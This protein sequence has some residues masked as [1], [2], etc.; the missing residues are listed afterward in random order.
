[1]E[2][3]RL[4]CSA[5]FRRLLQAR[6][7]GMHGWSRRRNEVK[8]LNRQTTPWL[9]VIL[10]AGAL[11]RIGYF[12]EHARQPDFLQPAV[13]A[14]YHDYWAFGLATGDWPERDGGKDLAMGTAPY[15]RPPGYPFFLAGVYRFTLCDMRAALAFQALLGLASCIVLF[16]LGRALFG[17]RAGLIAAALAAVYWLFI[18]YE[19]ELLEPVLLVLLLPAAALACLRCA[20]PGPR[21]GAAGLLAGALIG[22]A[23]LVKPNALALAPALA[24]WVFWAARRTR[25]VRHAA[26]AAAGLLAAAAMA[27]A[28]AAIRNARAGDGRVLISANGGINLFI[29]NHAQADGTYR[30]PPEIAPFDS[31]FDYPR[32]LRDL[33]V[34]LGRRVT[35]PEASSLFAARALD[36]M[37]E[38]P[39]RAMRL[40]GRKALL[41]WGPEEVPHNKVEALDRRGSLSLRIVP[42]GFAFVFSL[43]LAGLF[44]LGRSAEGGVGRDATRAGVLGLIALF[45]GVWFLT[46][47]PFFVS[48]Q[49]RAPVVPFLMLL[50]GRAGADVTRLAGRGQWR[51]VIALCLGWLALLALASNDWAG[52]RP[53]PGRWHFDRGLA[54]EKAGD[55]AGAA[56]EYTEAIRA[57]AADSRPIVNLGNL[58]F[59]NAQYAEAIDL[60]K[61]ALAIDPRHP[62]AL[63]NMGMALARMKRW[64]EAERCFIEALRIAPEQEF[65]ARVAASFFRD[66]AEEAL[67]NPELAGWLDADALAGP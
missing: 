58:M 16:A 62:G 4:T 39:G 24:A 8:G 31:C 42:I 2:S 40:A 5:A 12:I 23:C 11:L 28:P 32:V 46:H 36:W 54:Y 9:A 15:F 26:L 56:R 49:Y 45:I 63:C 20:G 29:G 6:M 50:A 61:A 19:G 35:Y 30:V 33:G 17:E 14:E 59:N 52:V 60:Y 44:P 64:P 53:S 22:L 51:R 66:C 57:N 41:F 34:R 38:N 67:R 47:L 1:M 37:R 18:Y 48:G 43:A 25:G 21:P 10:S 55:A 3:P 13:D 7:P 27:V 65:V